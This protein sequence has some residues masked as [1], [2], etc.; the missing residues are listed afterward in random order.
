MANSGPNTNASQ[1]FITLAAMTELDGRNVVFGQVSKGMEVLKQ[2]NLES[3][4]SE[5]GIPMKPVLIA[6]CGEIHEKR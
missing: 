1:F 6:D 3:G 4:T 2:V 5:L